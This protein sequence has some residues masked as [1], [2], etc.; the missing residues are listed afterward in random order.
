MRVTW[1]IVLSRVAE[2]S[3]PMTPR[4]S[5]SFLNGDG[6]EA[7]MAGDAG[8]L[9]GVVQLH[10]ADRDQC[11]AT[12]GER[13]CGQVLE[14]ANL[15]ATEGDARVAVLAFCPDLDLSVERLALC[16][17]RR[18]CTLS[19]RVLVRTTKPC[20]LAP[21]RTSRGPV[22]EHAVFHFDLLGAP[23]ITALGRSVNAG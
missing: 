15:V 9:S 2:A 14:L 7:E 13:V 17:R 11:V 8:D 22:L 20:G 21:G 4:S 5:R 19:Q 18:P 1:P 23:V 12:L 16:P 10:T 3:M 6:L